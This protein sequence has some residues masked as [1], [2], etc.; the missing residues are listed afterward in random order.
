MCCSCTS[1]VVAKKHSKLKGFQT[2]YIN[3]KRHENCF[4][5]IN[6]SDDASRSP[7]RTASPTPS[8]VGSN[9]SKSRA[10][11][12]GSK[13]N[14][15]SVKPSFLKSPSI[16]KIH[17]PP[18][19]T[20]HSINKTTSSRGSNRSVSSQPKTSDVSKLSN[21]SKSSNPS[22]TS[23]VIVLNSQVT[24]TNNNSSICNTLRTRS[25]HRRRQLSGEDLLKIYKYIR[26]F[27]SCTQTFKRFPL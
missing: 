12:A 27:K 4:K 9:I 11:S 2:S 16:R 6:Y 17:K 22:K 7:S 25:S 13:S 10:S 26:V 8:R 23:N 5:E 3:H 24:V 20:S 14:T 15:T 19:V 21:S 1:C 18:S